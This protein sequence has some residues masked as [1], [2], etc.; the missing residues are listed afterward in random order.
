[1]V[2][3]SSTGGGARGAGKPRS[4]SQ[5]ALATTG[6]LTV[7]GVLGARGEESSFRAMRHHW[8]N[9]FSD[10]VAFGEARTCHTSCPAASA[11]DHEQKRVAQ[12]PSRF[13]S[14]YCPLKASALA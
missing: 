5:E 13:G 10:P 12:G 6:V 7:Q 8:S 4:P 3:C 14:M 9:A 2:R 11:E 1:M